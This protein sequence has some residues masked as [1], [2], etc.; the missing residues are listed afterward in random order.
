MRA[1]LRWQTGS[2][3]A[4]Q[5]GVLT[6]NIPYTGTSEAL[7]SVILKERHASTFGLAEVI[8]THVFLKQTDG[9]FHEW[10]VT[11]FSTLAC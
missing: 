10:N 2:L 3:F 4:Y 9:S 6:K 7:S 1:N 11:A 8:L 5:L